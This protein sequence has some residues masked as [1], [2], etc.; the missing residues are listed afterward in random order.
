MTQP[1]VLNMHSHH[2]VAIYPHSR[3]HLADEVGICGLE[4]MKEVFLGVLIQR[5]DI[6]IVGA[7]IESASFFKVGHVQVPYPIPRIV[8][9]LMSRASYFDNLLLFR[10]QTLYKQTSMTAV[11]HSVVRIRTDIV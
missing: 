1:I 4:D 11:N 6:G 2:G 5:H 3:R 8:F 10:K 9:K 7:S